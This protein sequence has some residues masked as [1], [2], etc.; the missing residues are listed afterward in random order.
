MKYLLLVVAFVRRRIFLS[1]VAVLVLVVAIVSVVGNGEAL[2]TI[3]VMKGD[4]VSYVSVTGT[5]KPVQSVNLAF[6]RAGRVTRVGADVGDVVTQGTVLVQLDA[7]ELYAELQDA[8]AKVLAVKSKLDQLKRGGS[9]EEVKIEEA[10]IV[11][12]QQKVID[13]E[14]NLFDAAN[15]LFVKADDA[16]RNRMD[17]FLRNP[18][19]SPQLLFY[20]SDSQLRFTIEGS[21]VRIESILSEWRN[22]LDSFS[23][24]SKVQNVAEQSRTY[25]MEVKKLLD[26]GSLA[27]SAA[28]PDQNVT[29][30][31]IDAWKPVLST[32]RTNVST[33]ITGLY[34][35]EQDLRNVS[36]ALIVSE[37][38]FQLVNSSARPEEVRAQEALV[39]QAEAQAY[40]LRVQIGKMAIRAP[41]FGVVTMQEAEVGELAGVNVQIVS[42]MHQGG[43]EIEAH[44]PEIDVVKLLVGNQVSVMFDAIPEE[45]FAG[46][47]VSIQ[48]AETLIDGVAYFKV[49]VLFT[50]ND[51]RFK[52]GLTVDMD[53]QTLKKEGVIMIPVVALRGDE[54]GAY[55][56]RMSGDVIHDVRVTLGA[57]GSD[58][59]VEVLSGISEGDTL[60]ISH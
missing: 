54:E 18:R 9:I 33:A 14:R 24:F 53:I 60:L 49:K 45:T 42:L 32:G 28:T 7:S 55:V 39:A 11:Q 41:F 59:Q 43:F 4:L 12:A 19:T 20:V 51:P 23:D 10:K 36:T 40:K 13:A 27:L 1:S 46:K 21:R 50:V 44:V 35:S 17:Q 47:L 2:Q 5:T 3:T 56:T 26:D 48:P 30:T 16:I 6:E 52:S 57:R 37:R 29:Q 8:E 58:G 31:S 15:D 34:A 25:A 22:T 38:E